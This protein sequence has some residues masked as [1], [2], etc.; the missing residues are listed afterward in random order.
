[1]ITGKP[2]IPGLIGPTAVGKSATAL[3]LA[4]Q[5]GWEI[6]SADSR[7]VYRHLDIGTAKPSA[8]ELASVP[9][10]F[11]DIH[12]PDEI[13]SAGEFGREARAAISEILA[14]GKTPLVVGGSGLYIAAL[15]EGFFE[16]AV[17][18]RGL[19]RK[20]KLRAK[21]EGG[22]ALHAELA[23]VDPKSAARLHPND[24]H[25][26]V[27]ALEVYHASGRPLSELW[28]NASA[29]APF[30]FH[31]IGMSMPREELYNRIDRRVDSMLEL[32]LLDECKRLLDLGYSPELNALQ[33]VGY[34]EVFA[35]FDGNLT[36]ESMA[37]EIKRHTRNY[38]KRQMT[39]FRKNPNPRWLEVRDGDSPEK[40]A[41]L[42][43]EE[44]DSTKIPV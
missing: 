43:A 24:L 3:V 29:G 44:F 22:A 5:C 7:Q 41:R 16:P 9:H 10:H 2:Y 27:R 23:R 26:I 42:L 39:W 15:S 31:F 13:Y 4:A 36:R 25:R 30:E 14:R 17:S 11:I 37:S 28:E 21:Q 32:G 33:T 35:F 40:I 20:L 1:M 6:I 34:K 18:D 38:A 8:A 19:Q 12:N